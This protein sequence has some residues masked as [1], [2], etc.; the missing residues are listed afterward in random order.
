MPRIPPNPQTKNVGPGDV[1]FNVNWHVSAARGEHAQPWL[2]SLAY[3]VDTPEGSVV[4]TGDTQPCNS[5]IDL[6][7]DADVMLCMCWDDQEL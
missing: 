5:V 6:A 2:D 4:F 3:R 1:A 7:R